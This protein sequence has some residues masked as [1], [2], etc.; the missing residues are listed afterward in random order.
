MVME[1][2][3]LAVTTMVDMEDA[4]GAEESQAVHLIHHLRR[5]HH[6]I[7]SPILQ[8]HTLR[9]VTEKNKTLD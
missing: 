4:E 3:A 6:L 9:K 7:Q 2:V 5:L 8:V 1:A